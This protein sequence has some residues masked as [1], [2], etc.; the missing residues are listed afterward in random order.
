[1]IEDLSICSHTQKVH[2]PTQSTKEIVI[3]PKC[4]EGIFQMSTELEE[5]GGEGSHLRWH[6]QIPV[7]LKRHGMK[8]NQDTKGSK[9]KATLSHPEEAQKTLM[10][11][12]IFRRGTGNH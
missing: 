11:G 8:M 5:V 3:P 7:D 9:K 10:R 1:M 2:Q 6:W 4:K 12:T